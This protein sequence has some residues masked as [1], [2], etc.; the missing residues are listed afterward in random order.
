MRLPRFKAKGQAV[1]HCYSRA[2]DGLSLFQNSPSGRLEAEIF[3][4]MMRQV[5]AFTG[6]QVLDYVLIGNHF[7]LLFLQPERRQLSE[8]EILARVEAGLGPDHAQEL[9]RALARFV[10]QPDEA[11]QTMRLLDSYTSRMFD[12][13]IACKE[14]KGG[15]AQSYNRR[16][17]RYGA[18]WAE[19]FK[20]TLLEKGQ[21]VATVAAYIALNPVRANLCEDPKDYPY[22]GYAEATGKDSA[23]ANEGLRIALSLPE[24]AS[25]EEVQREYRKLLH[26]KGSAAKETISPALDS[27]KAQ[28]VIKQEDGTHSLGQRLRRRIRYFTEGIILG[29]YSFVES[30]GQRLKEKLGYKRAS[31]PKALEI[32][33]LAG[34]WVFHNLRAR[35]FD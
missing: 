19:R 25:R 15:F 8:S 35:T 29:S 20:S 32:F 12:I 26:L 2:V 3:T 21:A 13:S 27:A 28:Q 4:S 7:H 11:R 31:S 33:G 22:C 30:H 24:T 9:R 1:Y 18:L 5:E 23:L 6:V 10:G 34:L 17:N 16:H 14:L